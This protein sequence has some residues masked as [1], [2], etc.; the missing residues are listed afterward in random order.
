M[1][2][3]KYSFTS[4]N[5]HFLSLGRKNHKQT[6]TEPT[7]SLQFSL[8]LFTEIKH[9]ETALIRLCARLV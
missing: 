6:L 2:I 1:C 7:G 8:W 3:K 4:Y 5:S 9:M